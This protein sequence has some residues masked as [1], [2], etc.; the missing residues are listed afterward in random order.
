MSSTRK[1]GRNNNSNNENNDFRRPKLGLNPLNFIGENVEQQERANVQ[2]LTVKRHNGTPKSI[3]RKSAKY[4]PA[5]NNVKHEAAVYEAL[6]SSPYIFP[7]E[8]LSLNS[9]SLNSNSSQSAFSNNPTVYFNMEHMEGSTLADYKKTA[10]IRL[11]EARTLITKTAEALRWLA[12]KGFTHGDIKLD[13]VYREKDGGIR[14]FDFGS[15][16]SFL[17]NADMAWDVERDMT[18]F[19]KWIIKPLIPGI[20]KFEDVNKFIVGDIATQASLINFYSAVI[21]EYG[22]KTGGKAKTHQ[23]R[24]TRNHKTRKHKKI[25]YSK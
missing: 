24:K 4:S 19:V 14:I 12:E 18:S 16:K 3:M 2:P 25:R 5:I 8:G 22:E 21:E 13:N 7:Y 9:S 11:A 17:E 10:D 6:G 1:R 15:S 23:T 20:N